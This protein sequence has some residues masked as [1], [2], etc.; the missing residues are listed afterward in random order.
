MIAFAHFDFFPPALPTELECDVVEDVGGE[1]ARAADPLQ[2][3]AMRLCW[4]W[5]V[6]SVDAC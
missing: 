3:S 4:Y 6:A 1:G 2:K 5:S